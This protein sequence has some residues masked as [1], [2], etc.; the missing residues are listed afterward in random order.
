MRGGLHILRNV[1]GRRT[2]PLLTGRGAVL[3]VLAALAPALEAVVI[4]E[5][6]YHPP[7]GDERLEF[8]ELANDSST[9]EDISGY[10][11]VEGIVFEVPAGTIL[12]GKGILVICADVDLLTARHGITNAIGNFEGSLD[13]DGERLTLVD[14]A[15][16]VVQ[17]VR[18]RARGKWPVAPDGTGHTLVLRSVHLD[19]KEPESWTQSPRLGGSPGL[20]NFSREVVEPPARVVVAKG[21]LWRYAKGTA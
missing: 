18:Y 1:S 17:S 21:S 10:S 15:G 14:H 20:A 12:R 11:F 19:S 5:I 16:R 6:H 9:P 2:L 3:A 8:I 13:N 4:S 7:A